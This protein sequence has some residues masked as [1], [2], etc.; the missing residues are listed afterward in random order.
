MIDSADKIDIKDL[1]PEELVLW[2]Q[3]HGI[4]PYRAGQVLRWIYSRQA[5]SFDVIT[6]IKKEIQVLLSTHF[7]LNRL[8][9]VKVESSADG[10]HKYLFKLSDN[11]CIESVLIPEKNHLTLC[12]ST[13]VG[14]AQGCRFC[15]TA[16]SGFV[17]NLTKNE[18]VSQVRDIMMDQDDARQLTNIVL[19][20]MGEPLANYDNVL[21]AVET[22]TNR[23]IG[24]GFAS[25]RITISTAGLV[26]KLN[27]LGQDTGVN[28]AVSLNAT[29][30]RTRDMLMPINRRYPIETLLQACRNYP[31]TPHRRITF[32]YILIKGVNDTPEDAVRLAD[33]LKPIRSKINLIPFNEY[34]ESDF[35]P[36]PES[37][38]LRFQEILLHKNYTVLIRRSKGRDISAACGQLRVK[39]LTSEPCAGI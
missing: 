27:S 32:E 22:F 13:Q 25:R 30:N 20:G 15:L 5:D 18:I 34:E 16:R 9:R 23:E 29:D 1:T 4:A 19:M 33:L 17:R 14:C 31:L 39:T 28:L 3:T 24:L 11:N 2:L 35:L 21:R 26:S 6:D 37:A 38:I 10:S 36:P 8:T 7:S 12:I